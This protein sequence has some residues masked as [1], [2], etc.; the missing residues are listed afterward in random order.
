[1]LIADHEVVLS[2]GAYGSP[3]ILMLSGIGV[4]DELAP[5]GIAPVVDLPVGRELQDHPLVAAAGSRC[6][7]RALTPSRGSST[8]SSRPRTTAPG[9]SLAS[10]G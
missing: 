9:S 10:D 3:Q 4:A 1:M 5:L 6:E 2:A 8:I 7:P